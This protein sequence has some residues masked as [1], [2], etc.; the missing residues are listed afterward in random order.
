MRNIVSRLFLFPLCALLWGVVAS[1]CSDEEDGLQP[2]KY[3]YVQFKLYKLASYDKDTGGET[4][5]RQTSQAFTRAGA[6]KLGDIRK[7]EIELRYGETSITQTLILN[8]YNEE[9]AEFGLRTDK[10]QLL[11]GEYRIVGYRLLDKLDEEIPN[12][13]APIDEAFT[14][15]ANGLT[16]KDLTADVQARGMVQFRLTK[17]GLP[18][19]GRAAATLAADD[20]DK[21]FLFS[22]IALV[23]VTVKNTFTQDEI[24]FE[25]LKV[26]YE[27]Q[28]EESPSAD[29]PDDKYRDV[30]TAR[31]DSVVWLPTGTYRVTA[32]TVY[33][34]S[35][36]TKTALDTR[37]GLQGKE[38]TVADNELTEDAEIPVQLSEEA[39]NIK[40]YKA[41]REIWEALDGKNWSYRGEGSPAGANWN[42]NKEIDMW[43]DQPGVGLNSEG[44][45]T[46]LSLA[47]FGAK[48]VVPDAIGQLTELRILSFG[49]HDEEIGGAQGGGQLFGPNGIHPD[50]TDAQKQKMRMHYY[51]MFVRRDSREDLSEMLQWV[52]N[53]DT[54]L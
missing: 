8:S 19:I 11:A 33:S 35:G 10:L 2:G 21:S 38:F 34:K 24:D 40:D 28:Y 31:C 39:E 4:T 15:V 54:N 9:N 48:G 5:Q 14:V 22:N 30:G 3:G 12:A 53:R 29:D 43:G 20:R 7:M 6:D 36:S 27:E 23:S 44:R 45:V 52:I 32:Y 18:E 26:T 42:F 49:S 17:E 41:L 47:G 13:A 25:E 16:V 46:S 51:D 50:M 1:G 37:M